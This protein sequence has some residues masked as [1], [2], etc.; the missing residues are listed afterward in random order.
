[1]EQ[2]RNGMKTLAAYEKGALYEQQIL[3]LFRSEGRIAWFWNRTPL[4]VLIESGHPRFHANDPK[5]FKCSPVAKNP[6]RDTGVDIVIQKGFEGNNELIFVQV[7][8]YEGTLYINDLSGILYWVLHAPP[9]ISGLIVHSGG[10]SRE[11]KMWAKI[12]KINFMYV[13]FEPPL[14]GRVAKR[15]PS[16]I[17]YPANQTDEQLEFDELLSKFAYRG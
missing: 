9:N 5:I 15:S 12:R 8:N 7:K 11:L 1:M 14:S 3:E 6:L 2:T 4:H 10:L 17:V 16:P 13:P